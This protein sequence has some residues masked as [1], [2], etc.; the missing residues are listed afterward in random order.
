MFARMLSCVWLFGTPQTVACQVL[1]F[2]GFPRQE[3]WGELPFPS[4]GDLPDLE[5]M[6]PAL[7]SEFY[8]TEPSVSP[9]IDNKLAKNKILSSS[10]F[11]SLLFSLSPHSH[12]CNLMVLCFMKIFLVLSVLRKGWR[13]IP[14]CLLRLSRSKLP[15]TFLF[16]WWSSKLLKMS[17]ESILMQMIDLSSRVNKNKTYCTWRTQT[18]FETFKVNSFEYNFSFKN[19]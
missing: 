16:C 14:I 6:S 15:L 10:S 7:A 2:M 17:A 12:F 3:Y 18:Y 4:P 13:F 11:S 5:P 1:L 8:T 19:M 9:N